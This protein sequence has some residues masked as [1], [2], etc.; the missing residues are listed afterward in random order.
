MN[1]FVRNSTW[2][3]AV[4]M[5]VWILMGFWDR[6]N[7][8]AEMMNTMQKQHA[9]DMLIIPNTKFAH[10]DPASSASSSSSFP[11]EM[12]D[13]GGERGDLQQQQQNSSGINTEGAMYTVSTPPK[14][15]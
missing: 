7:A 8:V 9:Y 10:E 5:V 6:A 1:I 13:Y 14:P 3:L 4:A 15:K 12:N 11:S 2:H